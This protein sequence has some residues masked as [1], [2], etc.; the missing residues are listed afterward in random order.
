MTVKRITWFILLTLPA[1]NATWADSLPLWEVGVGVAGLSVPFYRGADQDKSYV[2]PL[3]Y[4]IYR[5]ER[6][7]IDKS[8]IRG[9]VFSSDRVVLDFSL[10]GGVPVPKD[11]G[12]AR[13]GMPSLDITLEVG[14]SLE[15]RLWKGEVVNHDVWLQLPLRTA[16]S[17][18]NAGIGHVGWIFAPFV[19]YTWR[20]ER[21]HASW[22]A[23]IAVGPIYADES[24]HDYFYTV[25]AVYATADRSAYQA[26]GGY[27]G[28]RVSVGI[29]RRL[30]D[31]WFGV[32]G[33]YDTLQGAA[34]AASP[35]VK[36]REYHAMGF[37][38]TWVF[39]KSKTQVND[40]RSILEARAQVTPEKLRPGQSS[41]GQ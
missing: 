10:A 25:D 20:N 7:K 33:R 16:F 4:V 41:V 23:N 19:E 5:G 9:N 32:F 34:F 13:A 26:S 27:S 37:A 24:Y 11:E 31:L 17:V 3:P 6:L 30:G 39:L 2:L 40:D 36:T 1:S 8:G 38:M 22:K 28:S 12:G 18:G 15:M 35:L 14:P 21:R 29:Q